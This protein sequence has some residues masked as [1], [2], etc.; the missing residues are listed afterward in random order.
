MNEDLKVL[1]KHVLTYGVGGVVNGLVRLSFIPIISF[2]LSPDSFGIYSLLFMM[3]SFLFLLFELGFSYALIQRYSEDELL[4]TKSTVIGTAIISVGVIGGTLCILSLL[5][6]TIFSKLLFHTEQYTPLIRIAIIIALC[7]SFFQLLLSILRASAKP[8]NFVF[9]TSMRGLS[10]IVFTISF[11]VFLSMEIEGFLWATL[12]SFGL[13]IGVFLIIVKPRIS[14]SFIIAKRMLG[15][16]LPLMSS[17]LAI[18]LLTYADLYL[19]RTLAEVRDVG[20]YQFA[21]EM[22]AVIALFL[23]SFERAWPQFV[24][25]RYKRKDAPRLFQNV[26]TLFF[27]TLAFFGLSIALFRLDVL[28]LISADAYSDSARVIPLLVCSGILY[29]TYYV[30]STGLL[31]SG[32]TSFF[33]LITLSA[34]LLNIL[35]NIAF[36]PAY[37]IVGAGFATILTNFV[38]AM[39]VLLLSNRYYAIPFRI[40]RIFIISCVGLFAYA[41][42]HFIQRFFP[43]PFLLNI[44]LIVGFGLFLYKFVCSC[45]IKDI[46]ESES[47]TKFLG[48]G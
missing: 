5:Q 46:A 43:T 16:G 18:W 10:H 45:G 12:L 38:M 48:K 21:Q 11:V 9:V 42:H 19:L 32:K 3:I 33:P 4:E 26:F 2:S 22:C 36:I 39:I 6:P 25:S 27:A 41:I 14:F 31:V 30:F 47:T 24:F 8:R 29:G 34:A 35:L 17:N 15:F 40:G 7:S 20:L 37:G 23:V 1:T 13:G 44:L 28:S